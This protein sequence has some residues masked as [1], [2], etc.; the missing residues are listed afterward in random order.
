MGVLQWRMQVLVKAEG[1]RGLEVQSWEQ[2]W[3]V[4]AS[5]SAAMGTMVE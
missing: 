4:T 3:G 2:R 1:L 5:P